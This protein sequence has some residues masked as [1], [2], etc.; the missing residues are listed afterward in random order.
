MVSGT[1]VVA[2]ADGY[3]SAVYTPDNPPHFWGGNMVEI[4]HSSGY[5]T[6][7]AHLQSY[8]VSLNQQISAGEPIGLSGCTGNCFGAHLH[9][10]VRH[11][12]QPT[13][14]FGWR[15]DGSDPL[16]SITGESA[17]CLWGDGQCKEIVV[18]AGSDHFGWGVLAEEWSSCCYG[19][20]SS[21][22]STPNRQATMDRHAYWKGD[23]VVSLG[24]YLVYAFVP[25]ITPDVPVPLDLTQC[26]YY[27]IQD[28]RGLHSAHVNQY[29]DFGRWVNLG[30]YYFRGT[31]ADWVRLE[32]ATQEPAGVSHVA[33]DA[34]KFVPVNLYYLP[35][36]YAEN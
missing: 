1:E 15:G 35:V 21:F 28:A 7:Y 4:S 20:G 33:F 31:T 2:A 36:A 30:L 34:V 13:D 19:Y 12:G 32:D 22:V 14:P 11:N 26:A 16:E 24:W 10:G 23:D 17:T 25:S 8:N 18:D 5:K 9:F 27:V 29:Y 3:V 6:W